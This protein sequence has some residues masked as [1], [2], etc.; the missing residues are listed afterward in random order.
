MWIDSLPGGRKMRLT[1]KIDRIDECA[2]E[3][4]Q[5]LY[6]KIVDYKSSARDIDL[7]SLI[8]GE[9]LQLLVY[10]DAAAR[11][12]QKAHPAHFTAPSRIPLLTWI[13]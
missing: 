4:G 1:G 7:E 8:E 10:L 6:V 3:E 2:D 9:Q 5:R 13:P 12:E 11:L